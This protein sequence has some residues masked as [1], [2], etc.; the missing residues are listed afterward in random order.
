MD[1]IK[2][3][4]EKKSYTL[5]RAWTICFIA[6]LFFFYEI[7]Q[8]TMFNTISGDL[9]RTFALST[10]QLCRLSASYLYACAVFLLPAGLL[11][12]RFSTKKLLVITCGLCTLGTGLLCIAPNLEIA[13]LGRILTGMGNAM[14]FLGCMRLIS[15]WFPAHKM[16]LVMGLSVT[17][18][19]S[20]GIVSQAPFALLV[21]LSTWRQ[22][23]FINTLLGIIITLLIAFI[24]KDVPQNYKFSHK[25]TNTLVR[26][27]FWHSL[28]KACL[29]LQNW[30]CGLYTGLLNLPIMM[31]GALWGNLYLIQGRG[32][33]AMQAGNTTSLI[34]LGLIIGAPLMGWFSYRLKSR[35]KPMLISSFLIFLVILAIAYISLPIMTL[36]SL[37]FVLG[38][39]SGAQVLTY[40]IV[41]E[42][43]PP[44]LES[45]CLGVVAVIV[46]TC[47]AISQM[48][49]GWLVNLNWNGL[50][51]NGIPIHTLSEYQFALTMLPLAF[52]VSALVAAFIRDNYPALSSEVNSDVATG[53]AS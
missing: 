25:Q 28:K 23:M 26:I 45:T 29:K 33:S 43:N 41:S 10:A 22:A 21:H 9:T 35:R 8:L 40:P 7:V 53:I 39:L 20:G 34:F 17:I 38:I 52:F 14:A 18:A 48:L 4:A 31:I 12:D 19:M 44:D 13:A 36:S 11:L 16:A 5:Y 49:F 1:D 6:S 51:Q 37:F 32:F 42:S 3:Q 50:T 46:N 30:L 27:S 2:M 24:I 15:K 47:G